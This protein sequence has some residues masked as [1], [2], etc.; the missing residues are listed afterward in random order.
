MHRSNGSAQVSA[1]TG[2]AQS[3]EPG[4][5]LIVYLEDNEDDSYLLRHALKSAGVTCSLEVLTTPVAAR[6]FLC[7][8]APKAPDLIVCDLGLAGTCGLDLLEWIRQQPHLTSVP[9]ILVTGALSCGQ[10]DRASRI[11]VSA[12][13][14]KS[15]D[16]SELT[17]QI[18][19][20]LHQGA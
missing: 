12:C 1:R 8:H 16:S 6:R 15:V 5:N 17:G 13:L 9:I 18:Q 10:R 11:G 3:A 19:R 2:W 14:E 20:L 7:E 4:T